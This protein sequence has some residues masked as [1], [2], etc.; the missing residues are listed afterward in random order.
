MLVGTYFVS[1]WLQINVFSTRWLRIS[2]RCH[3]MQ[4]VPVL[5]KYVCLKHDRHSG[6]HVKQMGGDFFEIVLQSFSIVQDRFRF[7]I[8]MSL[9]EWDFQSG[10]K[11]LSARHWYSFVKYAWKRRFFKN[12]RE[13]YQGNCAIWFEISPL[14]SNSLALKI[15]GAAICV[16]FTLVYWPVVGSVY[17]LAK[18]RDGLHSD[19]ERSWNRTAKQNFR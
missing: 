10:C 3:L 4:P 11:F 12:C 17:V 16:L 8:S 19:G 9:Y 18:H 15:T 1:T 5:Q 2:I 13:Q 6:T 14:Y 7:E